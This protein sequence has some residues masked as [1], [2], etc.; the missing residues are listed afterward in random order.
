MRKRKCLSLPAV[1]L[2]PQSQYPV[3]AQQQGEGR[4]T[5]VVRKRLHH[6]PRAKA[7]LKLTES[8]DINLN[9]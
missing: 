4:A 6:T 8:V 5:A 9:S 2:S 1:P 7:L 3:A